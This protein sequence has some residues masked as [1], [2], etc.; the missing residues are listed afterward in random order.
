M[1]LESLIQSKLSNYV[2][3]INQQQTY[4][5]QKY[6]GNFVLQ[7]D[8][9]LI[10]NGIKNFFQNEL[11]EKYEYYNSYAYIEY[12][13]LFGFPNIYSKI[14][15]IY[16][17]FFDSNDFK[18][19]L[20]LNFMKNYEELY[21]KVKTESKKLNE[22]LK[23]EFQIKK[24]EWEKKCIN[25]KEIDNKPYEN[26]INLTNINSKSTQDIKKENDEIDA[27]FGITTEG[28]EMKEGMKCNLLKDKEEVKIFFCSSFLLMVVL[29]FC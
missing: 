29:M 7:N 18:N 23:N 1:Q 5:Y 20:S 27:L 13:K 24:K 15:E 12:F 26:K 6:N 3:Y 8:T 17:I 16:S 25:E 21:E 4:L 11:S 19:L 22:K 9:E 28:A 10:K 2:D 14:K